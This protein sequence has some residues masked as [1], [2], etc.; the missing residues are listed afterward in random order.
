MYVYKN[1]C[2]L[3]KRGGTLSLVHTKGAVPY[4]AQPPSAGVRISPP[5]GEEGRE[6]SAQNRTTIQLDS[7]EPTDDLS[8]VYM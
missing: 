3:Y 4:T 5:G 2:A 1:L 8:V 7:Q 6:R